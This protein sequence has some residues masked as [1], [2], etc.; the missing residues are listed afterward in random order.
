MTTGNCVRSSG[1][2]FPLPGG[3]SLDETTMLNSMVKG[4]KRSMM[5]F[6]NVKEVV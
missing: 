4:L 5:L 3:T 2:S 1:T 6:Y